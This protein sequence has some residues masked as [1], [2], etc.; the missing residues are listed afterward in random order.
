MDNKTINK[1]KKYIVQTKQRQIPLKVILNFVKDNDLVLYGK[2]ALEIDNNM[3]VTLPI[4]IN[5][6]HKLII[7]L[8]AL[9]EEYNIFYDHPRKV[10]F[11]SI[12]RINV[13]DVIY[14]YKNIINEDYILTKNGFKYVHPIIS[15]GNIF[16]NYLN[17]INY[18]KLVDKDILVDN[19]LLNKLE[20]F[21][22]FE[23]QYKNFKMIQTIDKF[24]YDEEYNKLIEKKYIK[25]NENIIITGIYAYYKYSD[26]N[27]ITDI[28]NLL[29]INIDEEIEK[30]KK[31]DKDVLVIDNII[32]LLEVRMNI[33]TV[34]KKDKPVLRLFEL[35]KRDHIVTHNK[36]YTNLHGTYYFVLLILCI[37]QNVNYFKYLNNLYTIIVNEDVLKKGNYECF[38]EDML[39]DII[40]YIINSKIKIK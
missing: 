12:I 7:L 20:Y 9:R 5:T 15:F 13:I 25:K 18:T 36:G 3:E 30:I 27:N 6:T 8:K 17:P 34:Y 29:C 39:E 16:F 24:E 33:Y 23:K 38:Q 31:I 32:E 28:Y 35:N 2:T 37:T 26:T 10:D 1:L 4:C 19:K 22:L 40:K 21:T 14:I 11:G